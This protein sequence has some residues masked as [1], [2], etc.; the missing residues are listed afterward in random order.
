MTSWY[1][2]FLA[3][4]AVAALSLAAGDASDSTQV[5]GSGQECPSHKV[6]GGSGTTWV[7][8]NGLLRV[9]VDGQSSKIAVLDKVSGHEWRQIAESA[10]RPTP[11][12]HKLRQAE[13]QA[14]GV[15]FDLDCRDDDGKTLSV[16]VTATLGDGTS[17]VIFEVDAADRDAAIAQ[18][19]FLRPFGLDAAE[20]VLAVT[21]YSNGHVFPLDLQPFPRVSFDAARLELPWVGMCDLKTGVGYAMI[22]ET[23][24]DA[25]I[26]M[27]EWRTGERALRA[28]LL[29]WRPEKGRFG[30]PRRVIYHFAPAGGYVA[31]AKR[32]RQYAREH[33]LLV[34]LAEKAQ[35]NPNVA[36]L[37][38]APDVWGGDGLEFARAAKAAGVDKMLFHGR[39]SPEDMKEINDLGYLTSEYDN[40]HDVHRNVTSDDAINSRSD[41]MPDALVM[42]ADGSRMEAWLTFDK[43]TQSMKRC[44]A[45]WLRAARNVV[46]R[47]LASHPFRGRFLDVTTAEA[48][49]ECYDPNHP[50]TKRQ[51]RD[52]GCELFEYV[53]SQGLVAGGEQ[54][55]W[56][57]VPHV[58]YIEGVMRG[59]FI[60]WPAGHL[61][62]P[63][64]RDEKFESPW[65]RPYPTWEEYDRF[66][67]GARYRV[68]L[69]E[70][71]FHDCVVSTWYWGDSSDFL[72]DAAPDDIRAKDA[73]NILY[74]TPPLLWANEKGSWQKA[75]DVFLRTYRNTCKLHEVIAGTEMLTHEFVT[76]DH[77]VQRTR[78]SDGTE[79][80]VNFGEQPRE[81]E[82]GGR[83]RLLPQNGFAVKGPRIEQSLA[84]TDGRPVTTIRTDSYS[85]RDA[86]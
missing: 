19:P 74:G 14:P 57:A 44:P 17:D 34:T 39:T 16:A 67:I 10:D 13:G 66:G 55:I 22:V 45:L 75:R 76:P 73:F 60:P 83:R 29:G 32:Y 84:I 54:G 20:G 49:Y 69:W 70:L 28:P 65:G 8:E 86:N 4:Y 26:E 37:F 23:P 40:Y 31:L 56:W 62:R 61:I 12:I 18:F 68:P 51:W 85:Y 11:R 48:P 42:K 7:L 33:G 78:F 50:I 47:R 59:G 79:V 5:H 43:K 24:D 1:S 2:V 77:E 25:Y 53:R 41:Y 72:L 82:L 80:I 9:S 46:P 35:A 21:D 27:E 30:Y 36:L 6:G 3:F 71:V 38:G 63:K 15:S 81:V 58:D 64:S 52:L